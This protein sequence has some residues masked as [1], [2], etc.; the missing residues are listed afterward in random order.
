MTLAEFDA[1]ARALVD[2]EI[3]RLKAL[4]FAAAGELPPCD[5]RDV[6][7]GGREASLTTFR[8]A[9]PYGLDGAVLVVVLAAL[10]RF[11][12]M[13]ARHIEQ[14]LVFLPTGRPR[15][16]AQTELENSGG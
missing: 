13:S 8:Y 12:G 11:F 4:S 5:G 7:V 14:G 1:E 16:A 10:P 6:L 3:S 15:E 9:S 2:E